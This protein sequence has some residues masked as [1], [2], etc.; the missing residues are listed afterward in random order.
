MAVSGTTKALKNIMR[1]DSGINGDA[2]TDHMD[3]LPQGI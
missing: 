1:I 2:R 3:A